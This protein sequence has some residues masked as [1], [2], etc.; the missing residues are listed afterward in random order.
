MLKI[1]TNLPKTIRADLTLIPQILK[2]QPL[3]EVMKVNIREV[4]SAIKPED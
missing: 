4:K 3:P 2:V 1:A